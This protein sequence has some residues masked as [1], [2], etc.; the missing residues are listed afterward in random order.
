MNCDELSETVDADTTGRSDNMD[1]RTRSIR[2]SRW[3]NESHSYIHVGENKI[4]QAWKYTGSTIHVPW[5]LCLLHLGLSG[6]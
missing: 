3:E 5:I 4:K 6:T 1:H 2:S